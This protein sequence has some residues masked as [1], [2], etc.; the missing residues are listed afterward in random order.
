[1]CHVWLWELDHRE[2][3]AL[4]K[5]C[6]WTVV[7]ERTLESPLNSR[8]I[9]PVNRKGSKPWLFTGRTDA[10]AEAPILWPSNAKNWLT[11]K[12]PNAG[13]DWGQ[14]EEGVTE[15]EMVEWH[16]RL[17]GHE[18]EQ[19]LGDGEGQGRLACCSPWSCKELDTTYQVNNIYMPGTV[20]GLVR[21]QWT[22]QPKAVLSCSFHSTQMDNKPDKLISKYH[23]VR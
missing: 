4:K 15:D 17:N 7:L 14:E 3:W 8:E 16:H 6:F 5:W 9:K 13:K 23:N 19:T 22:T 11:G 18:F 10:E 2:D 12:D 1:M 21:Q 20:E